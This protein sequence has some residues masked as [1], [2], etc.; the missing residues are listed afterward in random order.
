[1]N[2]LLLESSKYV[3]KYKCPYCDKRLERNRLV[4]HVEKKHEDMIPQNYTPARVVFNTINKKECGRCIVC[5]KETDWDENKCRYNRLCNNPACKA[6]YKSMVE[7]R[8]KGKYGKTSRDMLLDPNHQEKMLANRRISG[9]YKFSDGGVRTYTGSYEKK[10]LEFFDKVFNCKSEDIVTP[11]PV[12]EYT[13]NGQ[14]HLWITD[15]FYI[16]YNLVIECKDGGSNPNNRPMEEYRAKQIAKEKAIVNE[17]KYNYLRLTN[18]NFEQLML[19]MAELKMQLIEDNVDQRII[20]IN[21]SMMA[22]MGGFMPPQSSENTY[23]INYMKKNVFSGT[24]VTKDL[25]LSSIFTQDID[26][27]IKET[28]YRYLYDADY[29]IY[30]INENVDNRYRKILYSVGKIKEPGYIFETIFNKHMY[31]DDDLLFQNIEE[32]TDFL[33]Y[34]SIE[35]NTIYEITTSSILNNGM[36]IP[37]ANIIEGVTEYTDDNGYFIQNEQTGLR[38]KSRD[39]SEY[40]DLELYYIRKGS[41][42]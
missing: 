36:N 39:K 1:M 15:I 14:K 24:A 33:Q 17:G 31:T 37:T 13:F 3:K 38:T 10:T 8:I 9:S 30:K 40:S 42:L 22:T 5:G 25:S 27:T 11:G 34:K 20:R 41:I 26:G 35:Y 29:S 4:T 16:P 12:I 6:K 7:N 28:D 19:I 32:T 23:I 18:N 21:E 2:K